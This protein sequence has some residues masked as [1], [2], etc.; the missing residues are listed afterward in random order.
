MIVVDTSVL[1]ASLRG[2]SQPEVDRLASLMDRERLLLGD[3]VLCEVLRGA[4]DE[5]EAIRLRE[6]LLVFTPV[7]MVGEQV[8]ARAA[9]HYRLLRQKG[10][11]V[12]N[13]VDLLIGTFCVMNRHR[14][15]H[16]DR[17]FRP[18]VEHLGLVEA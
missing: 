9:L 13:T 2:A 3:L 16:D 18:M 4:R 14:L 7:E 17:D 10:V 15:L 8:A 1:I 12:R 6:R 11:T 5:G